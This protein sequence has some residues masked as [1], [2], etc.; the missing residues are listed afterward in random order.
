MCV[1]M[2][3]LNMIQ[4]LKEKSTGTEYHIGNEKYV[5]LLSFGDKCPITISIRQHYTFDDGV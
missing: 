1:D 2:R 3:N 4:E 5:T